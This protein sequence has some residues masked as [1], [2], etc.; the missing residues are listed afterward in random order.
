MSFF[1]YFFCGRRDTCS[2]STGGD[3]AGSYLEQSKTWVVGCRN[4]DIN[5][6]TAATL[7]TKRTFIYAT[8]W[9]YCFFVFL[10]VLNYVC[11]CSFFWLLLFYLHLLF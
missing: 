8:S 6:L 11:L 1:G 2:W 7:K 3:W 5:E 4:A 9:F 10:S